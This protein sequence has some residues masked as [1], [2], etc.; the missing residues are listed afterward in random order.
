MSR[1]REHKIR[2]NLSGVQMERFTSRLTGIKPFGYYLLLFV[3]FSKIRQ[4]LP[5]GSV[6]REGGVNDT[7]KEWGLASYMI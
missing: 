3:Y 6:P 1:N 7:Y 5:S 4:W 2:G